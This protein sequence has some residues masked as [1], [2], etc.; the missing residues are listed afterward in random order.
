MNKKIG[1]ILCWLSLLIAIFL[2]VGGKSKTI[3]RKL[4]VDKNVGDI[5]YGDLYGMAGL[6]DYKFPIPVVNYNSTTTLQDADVITLGDSFFQAKFETKGMPDLLADN[7]KLKVFDPHE[8]LGNPLVY[9]AN[10]NYQ[11]GKAKIVIVETVERYAAKR[12]ASYDEKIAT[13]TPPSDLKQTINDSAYTM[14]DQTDLNYFFKYN[15]FFNPIRLWLNDL[16]F[17]T[18]GITNQNI[19][20]YSINPPML[21]YSEDVDFDTNQHLDTYL[22]TYAQKV[23]QLRDTL[24]NQYNLDMIYVIVPNKYTIYNYL[25]KDSSYN[26][27]I[28]KIQT[29]LAKN[30]I[31]FVDL[32]SPYTQYIKTDNSKL[33]YYPNDTHFTPIAKN[34]LIDELV[35]KIYE[36]KKNPQ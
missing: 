21:F 8:I 26:N 4:L 17:K 30:N 31:N 28:P 10:H 20:R 18:T 16:E 24:K 22:Q 35:E 5:S 25:D 27:F 19:G 36:H 29:E 14:F 2:L 23:K 33:L 9:L 1:L 3:G 11:K 13:S 6:T 12:M 34:I 7:L 15:I 32:Y